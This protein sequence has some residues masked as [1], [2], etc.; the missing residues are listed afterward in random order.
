MPTKVEGTWRL[1][2]RDLQLNQSFQMLSGRLGT[3]TI[4]NGRMKGN[5][6]SFTAD[7]VR[8]VGTVSGN[9]MS[10]TLVGRDGSW[11][12]ER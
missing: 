2:E 8:F 5:E 4:A 9:R 3:S 11:S 12:A 7:G 10:G 6:I 1:G